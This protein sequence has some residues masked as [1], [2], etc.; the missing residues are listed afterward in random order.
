VAP[1][2]ALI[3]QLHLFGR[4]F[5][6]LNAVPCRA[7]A[8]LSLHRPLSAVTKFRR[9]LRQ[10]AFAYAWSIQNGAGGIVSIPKLGGGTYDGTAA[11]P[12]LSSSPAWPFCSTSSTPALQAPWTPKSASTTHLSIL[13][14]NYANINGFG[15][16]NW[17]KTSPT[18]P[19]TRA[20]VRILWGRILCAG[21]A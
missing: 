14:L 2:R 3:R 6:A 11:L 9:P 16:S 15:Q 18:P 10:L 1:R 5:T 12:G 21:Y 20:G 7:D 17:P 13:V 4:H 19:S 8:R